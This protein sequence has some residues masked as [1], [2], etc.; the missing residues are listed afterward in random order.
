MKLRL[1]NIWF[2]TLEQEQNVFRSLSG[3]AL[4]PISK[5]ISTA[6]PTTLEYCMMKYNTIGHFQNHFNFPQ[7]FFQTHYMVYGLIVFQ[8]DKLWGQ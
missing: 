5:I 2:S 7:V 6:W 3:N 4:F 8:A 1:F